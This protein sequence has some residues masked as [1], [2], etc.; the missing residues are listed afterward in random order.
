MWIPH[1]SMYAT[2]LPLA[3]QLS[4]LWWPGAAQ[5][6]TSFAGSEQCV[7]GSAVVGELENGAES[8]LVV[9]WGELLAT[10]S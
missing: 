3:Q 5:S 6:E 1:Y 10:R 9:V 8:K 7:V 2:P 4:I